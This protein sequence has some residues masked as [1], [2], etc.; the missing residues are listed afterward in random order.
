MLQVRNITFSNN[1]DWNLK[2]LFERDISNICMD[3]SEII[4]GAHSS[5][6]KGNGNFRPKEKIEVTYKKNIIEQSPNPKIPIEVSRIARS[7]S[8]D[9]GRL[10]LF[11]ENKS[12]ENLQ[13]RVE[14]FFEWH[15]TAWL[16]SIKFINDVNNK[17]LDERE[18]K[19][20]IFQSS[21]V[22]RKRGSQLRIELVIPPLA[23]IR[24]EMDYELS[25]LKYTEYPV[26]PH[27]GLDIR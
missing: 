24:I 21:A 27:R 19:M 11:L 25:L 16:H 10:K 8:D 2:T 7:F 18:L 26:D 12:N 15:M 4:V 22:M 3:N 5:I 20:K 9:K 23:K 17:V 14:Q 1:L 6:E 13:V